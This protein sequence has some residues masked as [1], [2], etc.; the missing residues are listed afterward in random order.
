MRV[1]FLSCYFNHH[2]RY[3]SDALAARCDYAFIATTPYNPK[4]LALGWKPD[5]E[6]DYVCHYDT[7]TSRAN[8]LLEQA[9]V[10]I[11]GSAPE[12]LVE[13]CIRRGQLVF[14]YSERPL[15]DGLEPLKYLPRLIKWRRQNPSGGKIYLL[16]ASAYTAGDY[17]RFGL[18]RRKAYRWGYF[19]QTVRYDDVLAEKKK[20]TILWAGRFIQ[21]KHPER[22]LEVAKRLK[23]AG[24]DFHMKLIGAGELEASLRQ[25]AQELGDCVEL[26]GS[27]PP[28]QVRCAMEEAEIFL[29]TSDR[30]EGWGAVLNEA[31]NSGCAVVADA[32]IGS[33]PFLI[34]DG[35]NGLL[36]PTGD[37]DTLYNKVVSLL[38]DGENRQRLGRNACQTITE[39]WNGD[40][41]AERLLVLA[42]RLKSG[43]QGSPFEDGPCS[44]A[45]NLREDWYQ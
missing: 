14:R 38:T 24:F 11:T 4:R 12:N 17:G 43:Q 20:N 13:A 22:A 1:V 31:M 33:A 39:S 10:V 21:W 6:P 30:H 19:P 7:D 15:K 3:L 9:E 28:Q 5:D 29:F 37:V 16:C 36:Y 45:E 27:M 34:R 25:L 32:A 44:P 26:T 23:A 18:F 2:Q 8:A 42:Q 35:E 40:T 41:A